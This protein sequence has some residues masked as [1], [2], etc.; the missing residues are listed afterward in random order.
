[1]AEYI[2]GTYIFKSKKEAQER[3]SQIL[4]NW[5]CGE[6]IHDTDEHLLFALLDAHPW[7]KSIVGGSR[8]VG[9]ILNETG[10]RSR[11]VRAVRENGITV[12]MPIGR[13][14]AKRNPTKL[15]V[16]RDRCRKAIAPQI[17]GFK[18]RSQELFGG[19]ECEVTHQRLAW[20]EVHID[21]VYPFECMIQDWLE[22]CAW[23]Y[24]LAS[25]SGFADWHS[26]KAQLRVVSKAY[27][28]SRGKDDCV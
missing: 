14:F 3:Y 25:V 4:K 18:R 1:V 24:S 20:D 27:N 9:F 19:F 13:A 5:D 6:Y 7:R 12:A 16:F 28:L 17:I 22:Q 26:M 21:H 10:Y 23:D 2:I 8:I 11:E 15:E